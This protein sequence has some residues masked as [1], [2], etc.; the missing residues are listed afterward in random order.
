MRSIVA[1]GALVFLAQPLAG[2]GGEAATD[3]ATDEAQVVD[4]ATPAAD[5]GAM[6]D[7]PASDESAAK[8]AAPAAGE[9]TPKPAASASVKNSTKDAP[10][11]DE[12]IIDEVSTRGMNPIDRKPSD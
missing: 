3:E 8:E 9:A 5:A 4:E 12:V 11:A 1:L 10:A 6:D 7:A 2:C